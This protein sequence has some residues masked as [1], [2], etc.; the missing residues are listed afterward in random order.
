MFSSVSHAFSHAKREKENSYRLALRDLDLLLC[1]RDLDL[2]LLL[3]ALTLR[4][5]DLLLLLRALTFLDLDLLLLLRAF[6]LRDLDRLTRLT[7]L[8]LLRP[9]LRLLD[10]EA[11]LR[12]LDLLRL[13][14]LA[15]SWQSH[16]GFLPSSKSL[17]YKY[18]QRR[19]CLSLANG[20]VS[21]FININIFIFH[22]KEALLHCP[23]FFFSA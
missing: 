15:Y 1:L 19:L 23:R 14:C 7:L 13:P 3:R 8:D 12:D 9:T 18:Q 20:I 17:L 10:R 16:L 11:L 5:L 4:D 22:F 21:L 6:T 2:L